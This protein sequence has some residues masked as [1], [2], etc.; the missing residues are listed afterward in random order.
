VAHAFAA[1]DVLLLPTTAS[2]PPSIGTIDS[3]TEAFNLEQ[4]GD[5]AYRFAPYTELFNVTGQPA[6]SL[7]LAESGTGLPIGVQLVAPLG[8]DDRLL[9]IAAWLERER[10]WNARGDRL[11]QSLLSRSGRSPD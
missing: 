7:P 2:L 4:W 11:R 1:I 8:E 9:T 3:R 5:A 10:P 6:I